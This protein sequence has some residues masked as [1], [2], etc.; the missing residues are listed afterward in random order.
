MPQ[1]E[2]SRSDRIFTLD[3]RSAPEEVRAALGLASGWLLA[4]DLP[5]QVRGTV[6]L[7]LAEVL[8][9][10]VEHAYGGLSRGTIHLEI[11][12]R[13]GRIDLAIRD[14]GSAMPG[15]RPPPG[16]RVD[17]D[18]PEAD[19][20]EGGFGWFLIRHLAERVRYRREAGANVLEIRI[21]LPPSA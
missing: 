8:N 10:V 11:L 4:R 21:P 1:Q 6:E 19:L 16:D 3:L 7:V 2:V 5:P 12:P 20:P 15:G 14:T 17:L 18:V 9:N 13:E